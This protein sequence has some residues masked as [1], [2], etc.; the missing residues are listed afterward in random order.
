M[1]REGGRKIV[2]YAILTAIVAATLYPIVWIVL[3]STKTNNEIFT[4][5]SLILAAPV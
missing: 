2:Q 5:A 3:A 4:G 1:S